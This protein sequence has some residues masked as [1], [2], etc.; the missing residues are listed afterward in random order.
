MSKRPRVW[1]IGPFPPPVTGITLFTQEVIRQLEKTGSVTFWNCSHGCQHVT[2]RARAKRVLRTLG[3]AFK[4]L[5]NG[6]VRDGRLYLS[7]NSQGGLLITWIVVLVGRAMGHRIY[8]HHHTYGHIQRHSLPMAWIDRSMGSCGTHVVHCDQMIDDFQRQYHSTCGFETIFPSAESINVGQPR[9]AAHT[10]FRLGMLSNLTMDKGVDL[11]IATFRALRE[12]NRD[13]TLDLAGPVR[14]RAVG[15]LLEQA[16]ATYPGA[17]RHLGPLYDDAKTRFFEKIDALL[18]PTR[19][20]S[21]GLVLHEAFA[22]GAPVITFDRGCTNT[23]VGDRAGLVVPRD[24]DYITLAVNQI[25]RWMDS[26]IDYGAASQAAVEQANYLQ[27]QGRIQLEQF[28]QRM[29]VPHCKG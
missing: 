11:A 2:I 9:P 25:E 1:A 22:A 24:G 16:Q 14:S 20:E 5:W 18:F 6:R 28:A 23:L 4:L 27:Q 19:Y 13:V 26:S 17:V 10:P 7:A 29:F 3:C 12:K 21:W 15:R 8:L